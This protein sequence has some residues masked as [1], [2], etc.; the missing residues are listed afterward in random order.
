LTGQYEVYVSI[1]SYGVHY[2]GGKLTNITDSTTQA[3]GTHHYVGTSNPER[4]IIQ[5][6][7][8]ITKETEFKVEQ[9]TQTNNAS[10]GLG[11]YNYYLTSSFSKYTYVKIR[12]LK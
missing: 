10:H 3:E 9:W 8:T 2:T 5:T 6:V 12:K 4:I 11:I 7:F 1:P